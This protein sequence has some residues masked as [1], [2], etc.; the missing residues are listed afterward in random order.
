MADAASLSDRIERAAIERGG[1]IARAVATAAETAGERLGARPLA[2]AALRA[3]AGFSSKDATVVLHLDEAHAR[4]PA[5]GRRLVTLHTSGIGVPCVVM[6]TG[7]GHTSLRVAD[8]RGLSRLARN[9]V[10]DMGTMKESECAA[11]IEK[12]LGALDVSGNRTRA[13]FARQTAKLA[14]DWPQ[15]LHCVQIAL[16]EEL[17]RTGGRLLDVNTGRL[18]TRADE[19]RHGYYERRL[20]DPIFQIE[21]TLT[22]Q[23]LVDVAMA[24]LSGG[25]RI[26][27]RKL[28]EAAIDRAGLSGEP[29]FQ[30]MPRGAFSTAMIEKGLVSGTSGEW[31]IAT[32]SM[33]EWAANEIGVEP[34]RHAP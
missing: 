20:E 8:V 31:N 21:T 4:V 2:D 23:I 6:L 18:R 33:V 25:S 14:H 27:L 28:C 5:V 10:V 30:E 7:L 24:R 11:S 22:K 19:L 17:V 13:T 29:E 1:G 16:C 3:V 9:A 12:M 34:S 32:P 15:H 26:Q